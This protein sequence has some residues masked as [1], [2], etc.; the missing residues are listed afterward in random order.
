MVDEDDT[1]EVCKLPVP[2][3]SEEEFHSDAATTQLD[4]RYPLPKDPPQRAVGSVLCCLGL[5]KKHIALV[6]VDDSPLVLLDAI[7]AKVKVENAAL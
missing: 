7:V 6:N 1:V 4:S 5:A 2:V 3:Q